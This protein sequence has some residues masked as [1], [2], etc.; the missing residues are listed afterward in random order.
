MR[1]FVLALLLCLLAGCG[2]PPRFNATDIRGSGLGADFSLTDHHGKQRRLADF[3]GKAVILFFGYAHCADICPTTLTTLGQ[4]VTLLGAEAQ[5]VQVLFVTLDPQR[6]SAALLS[7]YVPAFNAS[8]L[9]LRGD[10]ANTEAAV[11]AFRAFD[12]QQPGTTPDS[13][14]I[15]HTSGSYVFDPQGRVRLYLRNGETPAQIAADLKLI[16]SGK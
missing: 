6:D 12:K 10:Q 8:F 5:Q 7:R 4:A 13:Y 15:D 2:E 3:R 16:L 1:V 9:G 14:T 11:R